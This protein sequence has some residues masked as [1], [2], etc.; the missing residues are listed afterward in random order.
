MAGPY[1]SPWTAI[2]A[3]AGG[4]TAAPIPTI[5]PTVDHQE[6]LASI[7]ITGGATL[8]GGQAVT[9]WAWACTE[10]QHDGTSTDV[11]ALV[12]SSSS[13][14]SPTL[15]PR[16]PRRVY[17]LSLTVT[18]TDAQTGITYGSVYVSAESALVTVPGPETFAVIV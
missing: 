11:T 15:S 1:P 14:Q 7:V 2:A 16:G 4:G 8:A 9:V 13:V 18:Q 6:D 10:I 17:N 12:L 3:T 5:S